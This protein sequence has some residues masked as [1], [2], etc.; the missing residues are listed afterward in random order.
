MDVQPDEGRSLA[1]IAKFLRR[2]QFLAVAGL[3]LWVIWLL[4]PILI[5]FVLG[6]ILGWLGDPLVD[7]LERAGRSRSSAV[8]LVYSLMLLILALAVVLLVPVI[9]EQ[10][11]T[12]VDSLPQYQNWLIATALPW[13][14]RTSGL[15]LLAW[16]DTD[17]IVAW[18]REHWQQAGGIAT[19]LLGYVSRSGVALLTWVL[20]LVLVPIVAYFFLRD[21]DVFVERVAALI[22]RAYLPTVSRL[23]RESDAVL[24]GFLRGQFMVMIAMGV[25]YAVGLQMVGLDLGILIG[26]IG[27]LFTFVPY[28]GPTVIIVFGSLAAWMEHGDWQHLLGVAIVWGLGQLLE[29]YVLTPKLVGERI[30]LHPLAVIFAV[31]AGG[32][33]FGFVGMLIALPVAAVANVLMHFAMERY[34]ASKVYAGD[35][36]DPPEAPGS[37]A[38]GHPGP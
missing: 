17:R 8:L 4:S 10:I 20:N 14:E 28:V 33:L 19:T 16:L 27:G 2:L 6:A 29:S 37:L 7:R 30:G 23:A 21:W 32:V 15:E 5:P 22:P 12:L 24:G 38:S 9:Q 25:F 31:M 1:E 11:I 35:V 26:I 3:A 34:Q 36:A 18:I 13:L